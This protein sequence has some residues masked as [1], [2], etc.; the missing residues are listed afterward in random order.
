MELIKFRGVSGDYNKQG[1]T[2]V[3]KSKET[4]GKKDRNIYF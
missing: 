4:Q 3:E 2:R 1:V